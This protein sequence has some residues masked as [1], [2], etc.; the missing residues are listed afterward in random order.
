MMHRI[1]SWKLMCAPLAL[2]MLTL[3]ACGSAPVA[4][5]TAVS[6]TL[7][8]PTVT[9]QPTASPVPTATTT[10][11]PVPATATARV[12]ATSFNTST[13]LASNPLPTASLPPGFVA[14]TPVPTAAPVP[15]RAAP[16]QSSTGPVAGS[17]LTCPAGYPVKANTNSGIFHVPG[18][19][20]YDAT[21]ARNCYATEAA[22]QTAGFRK[23]QV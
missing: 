22:A 20:F 18:Q 6:A 7:A 8:P 16:V 11:V 2:L 21:N 19:R 5:S 13:P 9:A 1:P 4:T 23:S 14:P 15:T 10:P 17:G 3:V 12:L